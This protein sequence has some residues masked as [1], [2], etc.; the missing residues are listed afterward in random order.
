MTIIKG[1]GGFI[2]FSISITL[3]TLKH[4]TPKKKKKKNSIHRGHLEERKFIY[5][6][7]YIRRKKEKLMLTIKYCVQLFIKRID[8]AVEEKVGE[9]N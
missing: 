6:Y 7:I 4:S 3:R 1:S 5:I 8:K 9:N 2:G